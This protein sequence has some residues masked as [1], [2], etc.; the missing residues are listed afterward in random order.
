MLKKLSLFFATLFI[1]IIAFLIIPTSFYKPEIQFPK[2]ELIKL[3]S[4]EQ[5][6]GER[7]KSNTIYVTEISKEIHEK[8]SYEFTV[9]DY[10]AD[11]QSKLVLAISN[12][13]P[14]EIKRLIS[15]GANPQTPDFSNYESNYPLKVA[16]Y[17]NAEIVKILLDNGADVDQE[18]CCCV[19][20]STALVN[21]IKYEK[22][23]MVKLLLERGANLNYKPS[24]S[25]DGIYTIPK[26]TAEKGN[27]EIIT[28]LENASEN[29]LS[30]RAKFRLS[31]VISLFYKFNQPAK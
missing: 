11:L 19:S 30:C 31:R 2:D 25:D 22:P 6:K 21:A 1:G 3:I 8:E 16:S 27:Q 28:L 10:C 13:N 20:C 18:F 5:N 29:D 24:F 26:I 14:A 15:I 4:N 7:C 9:N 23:E 12:Q 17:Q